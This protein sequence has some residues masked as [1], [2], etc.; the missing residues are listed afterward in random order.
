ME[1]IF[2]LKD[3]GTRNA[4]WWL[5]ISS[6]EELVE[7]YRQ[8]YPVQYGRAFE[9]YVY[10]EKFNSFKKKSSKVSGQSPWP[11]AE[12]LTTAAAYYASGNHLSILDGL[13]GLARITAEQQL[14]NIRQYGEVFINP[15][16]GYHSDYDG[17]HTYDFVRRKELVFP[18]FKVSDIRVRQFSGGE[19]YYAYIGNSQVRD[20]DVLKWDSY[21]EAYRKAEEYM[22]C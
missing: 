21:E 18:D 10:G 22:G 7:Y 6:L 19:H 3:K 20:G 17:R 11:E 5:K 15:M 2:V 13:Q 14:E 12:N 9:N 4:G 16:G 8:T 1:W